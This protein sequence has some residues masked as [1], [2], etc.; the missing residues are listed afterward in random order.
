MYF[1]ICEE[2][3]SL[4]L[5]TKNKNLKNKNTKGHE[6]TFRSDGHVYYSYYCDGV[7]GVFICLN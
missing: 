2:G 3:R 7:M 5:I 6:E 4:A 1:K